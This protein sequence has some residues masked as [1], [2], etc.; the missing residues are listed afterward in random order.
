MYVVCR[1]QEEEELRYNSEL[2]CLLLAL[3]DTATASGKT[4]QIVVEE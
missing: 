2:V 4:R 3:L 1:V